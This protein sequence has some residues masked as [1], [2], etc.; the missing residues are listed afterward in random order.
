M[1]SRAHNLDMRIAEVGGG[2]GRCKAAKA[3]KGKKR[4]IQC[5]RLKLG[6]FV[7]TTRNRFSIFVWL[8][9]RGVQ[10]LLVLCLMAQCDM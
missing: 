3:A 5:N 2:W 8:V 10:H 1:Q 9:W 6:L 4:R 7:V